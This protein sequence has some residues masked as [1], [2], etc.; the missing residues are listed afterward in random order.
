MT[1]SSRRTILRGLAGVGAVGLAAFGVTGCSGSTAAE[2]E[3]VDGLRER[4]PQI[5]GVADAEV[6]VAKPFAETPKVTI[7]LVGE[8]SRTPEQVLATAQEVQATVNGLTM[9]DDLSGAVLV[10]RLTQQLGRAKLLLG[11][12][13]IDQDTVTAQFEAALAE[14]DRGAHTVATGELVQAEWSLIDEAALTAPVVGL[15]NQLIRRAT[16]DQEATFTVSIRRGSQAPN[17]PVAAATAPM[18]PAVARDIMLREM[19]GWQ[20]EV[21]PHTQDIEDPQLRQGSVAMLRALAAAASPVEVK[22]NKP[23]WATLTVDRTVQLIR[24]SGDQAERAEVEQVITDLLAQV[25]G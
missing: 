16:V 23:W 10:A 22:I 20:W 19:D 21:A 2:R 3:F 7:E 25:N 15:D 13:G 18:L 12:A 8:M 9:P 1:L 5:D 17:L 11:L 4:L 14:V 24:L 6:R